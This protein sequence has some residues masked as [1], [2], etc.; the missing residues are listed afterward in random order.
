MSC[1]G[2][3]GTN[4]ALMGEIVDDD[5]LLDAAL[6]TALNGQGFDVVNFNDGESFLN[7]ARGRTPD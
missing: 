7:A 4:G 5:P 1:R 3:V 2:H 6:T